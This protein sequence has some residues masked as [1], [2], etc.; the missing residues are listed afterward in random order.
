M[1]ERDRVITFQE[2]ADYIGLSTATLRRLIDSGEGP[3]VIQL[4]PR[5]LGFRESRL[6]AWL[7]QREGVDQD[8]AA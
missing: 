2:A 3:A 8:H 5:R 7:K 4:S 1:I 6:I